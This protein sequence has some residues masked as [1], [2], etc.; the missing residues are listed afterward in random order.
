MTP[1]LETLEARIA[2]VERALVEPVFAAAPL[3]MKRLLNTV[4]DVFGVRLA[5][6]LSQRRSAPIAL[7]RQ[8][9]MHQAVE[10][11]GYSLPR[12]GRVL[13]RDHTTVLHGH[14]RIQQLLRTDPDLAA[15]MELI[16]LELDQAAAAAS[17]Q[18]ERK[19]T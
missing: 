2:R 15:R 18:P 9:A 19:E 8:V 16:A 17:F 10:R 7:A 13:G 3:A 11:L 12:I 5:Q 4:A 6:I 14:R 1:R